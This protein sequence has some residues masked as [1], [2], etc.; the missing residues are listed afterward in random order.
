MTI[1]GELAQTELFRDAPQE[2]L[3]Q[4]LSRTTPTELADGEVLLSP[5]RPNHYLY[6]LLAGRLGLHFG[7]ADSKEI[8]ELPAGVSVGEISLIDDAHPTAWIVAKGPCRVLPLPRELLFELVTDANPL[9]ANLLRLLTHWIKLNTQRI[10][11]DQARIDELANHANIDGLTGLYNRRWMDNALP[12]L[13]EQSEVEETP[14]C[15]LLTDVDHFKK[16]NDSQGHQ[17]GDRALIAL[18]EVLKTSVRPYD[19]ATRYGG[20]EFLVILPNTDL[21]EA[22]SIAERIRLAAEARGISHA[23]G[24]PLPGITLSIGIAER[25]A[26]HTPNAVIEAADACLYRA[27]AEGRNR[28]CS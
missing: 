28:C 12:R 7:S 1:L 8:R 3:T 5:E 18:G 19:Y 20:E 24:T 4:V 15:V 16:Y 11:S 6:V 26:G 10:L 14:L 23:D 13:L 9:A 27:K 22:R 25:H 17:G 21:D 2:T